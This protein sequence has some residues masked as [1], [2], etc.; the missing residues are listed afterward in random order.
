MHSARR[1]DGAAARGLMK[2]IARSHAQFFGVVR[3]I[4]SRQETNPDVCIEAWLMSKA[5]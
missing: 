3:L 2:Q 1:V 5:A 4:E